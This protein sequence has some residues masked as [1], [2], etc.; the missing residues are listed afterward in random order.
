MLSWTRR[1][2]TTAAVAG[3]ALSAMSLEPAAAASRYRHDGSAAAV[4]AFAGIVGTIAAIAA[5]NRHRDDYY[6]PYAYGSGYGVPYGR[7]PFYGERGRHWS[8]PVRQ[9]FNG[10]H[11]DRR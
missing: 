2:I 5:S 8:P 1:A 11:F 4:A 7:R 3:I 6:D 9:H 10:H